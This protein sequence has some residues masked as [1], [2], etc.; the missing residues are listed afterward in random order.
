MH[1]AL[2]LKN[3]SLF[4]LR[5]LLTGN[6][7]RLAQ[8]IIWRTKKKSIR[9]Q[10]NMKRLIKPVVKPVLMIQVLAVFQQM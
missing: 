3:F 5:G 8:T 6:T 7:L 2:S 9:P 10:I 4:L 1:R